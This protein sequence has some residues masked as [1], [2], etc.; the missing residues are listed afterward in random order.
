MLQICGRL[1]RISEGFHKYNCKFG[2]DDKKCGKCG[3]IYKYCDC[4]L[5]YAIF[6][7]DLIEYKCGIWNVLK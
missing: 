5:E 3:I 4:F 7:D 1:I 2:L 6:K